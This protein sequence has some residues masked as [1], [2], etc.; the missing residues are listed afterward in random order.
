MLYIL[1]SLFTKKIYLTRLLE[2][3]YLFFFLLFFFY[4]CITGLIS[5]DIFN[6]LFDEDAVIFYFR[7]LFFSYASAILIL[8]N[9]DRL[10]H[11]KYFLLFAILIVL[12]DSYFQFIFGHNVLGFEKY[13]TYRLTS[14]FKDE[15]IVGQYLV[16]LLPVFL[17]IFFLKNQN[18]NMSLVL[19]SLLT[20]FIFWIVL[21]SGERLSLIII[22]LFILGI[23]LHKK[24]QKIFLMNF[25]IILLIFF[26]SY[27]FFDVV[28]TRVDQTVS[29]LKNNLL[30]F[31]PYTPDHEKHYLTAVKMI[32]NNFFFG[33][34][35]SNFE[36]FCSKE[37]YFVEKGC[38]SH[39]HNYYLQIFAESG[40][41]GFVFLVT[42]FIYNLIK[43]FQLLID[44]YIKKNC[45]FVMY[46]GHLTMLI[47]SL[48]FPTND[49][50]NNHL[51]FLIFYP[52]VLILLIKGKLKY[53]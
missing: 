31:F 34:G 4:L 30:T 33:I 41:I 27:S 26:L 39:P 1:L 9:L 47:L 2:T 7:Y 51:N 13:E 14:F 45:S 37:L 48:P 16:K 50:Y 53:K 25:L 46:I 28:T 3:H 52:F 42:F 24:Y 36:Q 10:T 40:F 43:S 17:V 44:S 29:Q 19:I 11:L 38:A 12:F 15:T 5:D 22:T 35:P 49:F 6:S 8:N 32:K 23:S 21:L 20:L 18:S